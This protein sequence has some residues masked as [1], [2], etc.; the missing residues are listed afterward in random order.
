MLTSGDTHEFEYDDDGWVVRAETH[1]HDVRFAY[2]P[3]HRRVRDERDGKGVRHRFAG[4]H[5]LETTVLDRF[6][7]EYHALDNGVIVIVRIP[8]SVISRS[9]PS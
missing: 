1:L 5:L 8:R 6:R 7:T 2:D 9:S 3:W 4:E